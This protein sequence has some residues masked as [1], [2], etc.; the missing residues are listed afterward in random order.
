MIAEV[1]DAITTVLEPTNPDENLK[2]EALKTFKAI[3]QH[4][5]RINE[6]IRTTDGLLKKLKLAEFAMIPIGIGSKLPAEAI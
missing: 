5:E 1:F 2:L 3:L 4:D 6:Q